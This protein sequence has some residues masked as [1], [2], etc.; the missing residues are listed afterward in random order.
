MTISA[1]SK[2]KTCEFCASKKKKDCC[3]DKIK[4]VKL[5]VSQEANTQFVNSFT[6]I[7]ILPINNYLDHIYPVVKQNYFSVQMNAPPEKY[8]LPLFISYCNFRI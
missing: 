6:A 2:L 4:I 5:D 8:T 3:K 1:R 7:A